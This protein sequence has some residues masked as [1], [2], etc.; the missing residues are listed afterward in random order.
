MTAKTKA[1]LATELTTNLPDNTIGSITPALLRTTLTDLIDSFQQFAGVNAQIGTSYTVVVGDYGQLLT[2]SN[3][4]AVAVTLPQATS[5]FATFSFFVIN[6]GAGLVT[7]TPTT[8]TINGAASLALAQGWGAFIVSDGTN[9]QV[10]FGFTSQTTP[11]G[12]RGS[13]GLNI[14][15][16]TSHGDSSYNIL[17]T[18]R[19]VG[20]SATLSAPRTWTLPLANSVNAGQVLLV[21][22]F[23]SGVSAANTLSVAR[24]G[25]DTINGATS[26]IVL[27]AANAACLFI[28]DGI[29]KWT[30]QTIGAASTAGVSTIGGLNGAVGLG[31]GLTTAGGTAIANTSWTITVITST[32]ASQAVPGGTTE[33]ILE[34]WGGGGAGGGQT[35]G[36][37]RGPGG[38]GGQYGWHYYSGTM[39]STLNIT[40][41][42]A[43][44]A[45]TGATGGTG[46]ATS[47]VGANLGTIS[48]AG[49]VGALAGANAGGA[50]GGGASNATFNIAGGDGMTPPGATTGAA[51]GGSSPR[52]GAGGARNIGTAGIVPG[53]GGS[54]ENQAG[55]GAGNGA[56]G[57]VI[58]YT[59]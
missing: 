59:R 9:Y 43:G 56:K 2:L 27:Q 42:A 18:D 16:L 4:S 7:I 11:A 5:S 1:A 28:S 48:V 31:R 6:K 54:G 33:M 37:Q 30:A 32:N 14:D 53:G 58:M 21:A 44:V 35:G 29:S 15:Q 47:A 50:G 39:D 52:G 12:A 55:G 13:S 19:V 49:G 26:A 20:T 25:S 57:Q 3:S 36:S 10:L 23:A 24:S 51:A 41:G 40:I 34:L 22:D 38:G 46:G 17:S 45:S 8:S